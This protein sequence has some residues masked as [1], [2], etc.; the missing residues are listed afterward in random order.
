[1]MN[2]SGR[3]SRAVRM[4]KTFSASVLTAAMNPRARSM[5]IRLQNV[6]AARVRLDSEVARVDRRLHPFGVALDD[7]ERHGLAQELA[8]DD[9]ADAAEAADDEVVGEIVEHASTAPRGPALLQVSLDQPR[10]Q[11]RKRVEHRRDA[12]R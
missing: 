10:H 6:L 5:P 12:E 9:L 7:D 1:M 2:R 8:G 11:E 3:S 4:A